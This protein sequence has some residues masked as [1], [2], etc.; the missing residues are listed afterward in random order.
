MAGVLAV[1]TLCDRTG[2]DT[3]SIA[4]VV[5][6]EL[7]IRLVAGQRHFFG[8]DDNNVVTAVNVRCELRLV[9]AAQARGDDDGETTQSETFGIDQDPV[10]R[11]LR[12]LQREGGLHD[13]DSI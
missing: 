3:A 11:H 13:T 9:L 4:G 5:M 7:L 6:K 1:Q 2:L 8:V 10:L 12:G